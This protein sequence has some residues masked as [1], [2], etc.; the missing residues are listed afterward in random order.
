MT[1]CRI[2]ASFLV[3]C[4]VLGA[5]ASRRSAPVA[6]TSSES[7]RTVAPAPQATSEAPLEAP[8]ATSEA[9]VPAVNP[10]AAITLET[11]PAPSEALAKFRSF[12]LGMS[13]E[14]WAR[15]ALGPAKVESAAVATSEASAATKEANAQE[16]QKP[17]IKSRPVYRRLPLVVEEPGVVRFVYNDPAD[18]GVDYITFRFF[19][20]RLYIMEIF[21]R[22]SYFDSVILDDFLK[23]VKEIYGDPKAEEW[24]VANER[25]NLSW[26]DGTYA[27]KLSIISGRPFSLVFVHSGIKKEEQDYSDELK[28]TGSGKKVERLKF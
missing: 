7:A 25:G 20:D 17:K 16:P 9:A 19:K 24:D 8:T 10:A 28:K 12:W 13:I 5:C 18:T 3:A 22:T 21:Y 26:D 27:V 4:L 1:A 6:T 11:P 15:T 2:V 23:K 14:N